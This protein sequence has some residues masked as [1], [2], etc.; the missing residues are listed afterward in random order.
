LRRLARIK[1]AR[2]TN[3]GQSGQ[4]AL[5]SGVQ[6]MRIQYFATARVRGWT[7]RCLFVTPVSGDEIDLLTSPSVWQGCEFLT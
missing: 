7:S 2:P 6:K 1:Q 3:D 5:A 4:T